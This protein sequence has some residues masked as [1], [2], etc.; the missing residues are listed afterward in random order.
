MHV[1]LTLEIMK[2][3]FTTPYSHRD[4]PMGHLYLLSTGD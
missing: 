3:F 2:V 1:L 4:D